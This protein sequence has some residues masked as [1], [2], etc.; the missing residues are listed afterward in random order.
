MSSAKM[1]ESKGAIVELHEEL[2]NEGE[3]GTVCRGNTLERAIA[4]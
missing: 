4:E 1:V 3:I 2:G